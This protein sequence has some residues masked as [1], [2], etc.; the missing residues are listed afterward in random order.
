MP[1]PAEPFNPYEPPQGPI[2]FPPD[3]RP[4]WVRVGLWGCRTRG[5]ARGAFW[6]SLLL[7]AIGLFCGVFPGIVMWVAVGWYWAAIR[8]MDRERLW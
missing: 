4:P 5:S 1:G 8:W 3:L 2:D 7:S 6:F